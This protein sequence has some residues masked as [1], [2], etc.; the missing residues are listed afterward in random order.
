M[1]TTII[2]WQIAL[3]F[4]FHENPIAERSE[5]ENCVFKTTERTE[6][7]IIVFHEN[8]RHQRLSFDRQVL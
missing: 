5:K 3:V 4:V 6:I 7:I 2:E 8:I 1:V